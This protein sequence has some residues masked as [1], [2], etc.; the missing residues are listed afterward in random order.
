MMVVNGSYVDSSVEPWH[1]LGRQ[2]RVSAGPVESR[3]EVAR[4]RRES[5]ETGKK[6]RT[7]SRTHYFR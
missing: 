4:R 6:E 1:A 3:R 2:I 5:G 7:K